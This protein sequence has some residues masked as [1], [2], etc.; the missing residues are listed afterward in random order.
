VQQ[1][2]TEL[3]CRI[4]VEVDREAMLD[5]VAVTPAWYPVFNYLSLREYSKTTKQSALSNESTDVSGRCLPSFKVAVR[6]WQEMLTCASELNV[7]KQAKLHPP[8]APHH[9]HAPAISSDATSLD[10]RAIETY[11]WMARFLLQAF[12]E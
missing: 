12:S 10:L 9:R 7:E 8:P 5:A 3:N 4:A 6:G 11:V 2:T 1:G